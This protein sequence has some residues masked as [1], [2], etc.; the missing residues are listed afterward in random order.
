MKPPERVVFD[1]NVYF[2]A[3]LSETG[4]AGRLL[5]AVHEKSLA[6]FL[7]EFVLDELQD[8]LSRPHLIE[9]YKFASTRVAEYLE[10]LVELATLVT[11]VPRVFEFPRDPQDAHYVDLALAVDAKLIVSRDQDLL[12]LRDRA[13]EEG[14]NFMA[15]FPGLSILTP[16][17][18]LTL[19]ARTPPA[20]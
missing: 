11:D 18:V 16:P 7:S 4:P 20:E 3:F 10:S 15:R 19:L 2:Q 8:V 12:S 5:G 6:L 9:K 13:T 14:R 1:C 17:E